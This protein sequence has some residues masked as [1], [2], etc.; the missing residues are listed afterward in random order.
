MPKNPSPKYRIDLKIRDSKVKNVGNYFRIEF[1]CQDNSARLLLTV[2]KDIEVNSLSV[3]FSLNSAIK[4]VRD[5][6]YNWKILNKNFI[7]NY[8]S[9]KAVELENGYKVTGDSTIGSWEIKQS[10]KTKIKWILIH[11]LLNPT[12]KIGA[13]NEHKL[14]NS[15]IIL[16]GTQ[17]KCGL[18]FTH[19]K[20]EEFSRSPVGFVPVI[21]FTDHADFDTLKSLQKQREIFRYFNM[22]ISKSFFMYQSPVNDQTAFLEDKDV[23]HEMKKWE[24]E[25]HELCYHGMSKFTRKGWE[26]EFVSIKSPENLNKINCFID[27]ATLPY[28][29]TRYTDLQRWYEIMYEKGVDVIWN[30]VDSGDGNIFTIN[31]LNNSGFTVTKTLKSFI[32]ARSLGYKRRASEVLKNIMLYY[33][34]SSLSSHFV[35]INAILKN[36]KSG[37]ITQSTIIRFLKNILAVIFKYFLNPYFII[38]F[39]SGYNKPYNVTRY[40]PVIFSAINQ[41]TTKINV[42]QTVAIRDFDIS[43]SKKSIEDFVQDNGLLI[44]HTYFATLRNSHE[45]RFFKDDNYM[46]RPEVEDNFNEIGQLIREGKI[47]NPTIS[48]LKDYFI[49]LEHIEFKHDLVGDIVIKND[50]SSTIFKRKI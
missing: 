48:Q 43:F 42:F 50:K 45:G 6:D 11:P 31:Q 30:Y 20:I 25:G 17:L 12:P 36:A 41:L 15:R 39:L 1:C 27:H 28:N 49:I 44:A 37:Y 10:G 38:N 33:V 7:Q 24:S 47:W 26:S 8:Y 13:D 40:S 14:Y 35:N 29:Y 23:L 16:S 2:L 9:P 4:K 46:I 5:V 21:C 19:G 3:Y 22:K 34:P 18:L 32:V